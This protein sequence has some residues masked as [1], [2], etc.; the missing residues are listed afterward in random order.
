MKK[1]TEGKSPAGDRPG[2]IR[3]RELMREYIEFKKDPVAAAIRKIQ[4]QTDHI[5]RQAVDGT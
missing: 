3:A 1:R 4:R 2:D 5:L